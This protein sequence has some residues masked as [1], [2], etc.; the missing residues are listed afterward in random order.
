MCTWD[1]ASERRTR[2]SGLEKFSEF[3]DVAFQRGDITIYKLRE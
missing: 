1:R 3:M 2:G